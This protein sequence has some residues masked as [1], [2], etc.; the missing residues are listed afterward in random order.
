MNVVAIRGLL[1]SDPVVRQLTSGSV[2]ASLEVSTPI[3]GALASVPVAWFDPPEHLGLEMGTEVVV[4]GITRRRFF[5]S[6][7]VTQSR[8]EVVASEVVVATQKRKVRTV[9]ERAATALLDGVGSA[10]RSG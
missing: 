10:V 8:T 9:L 4:V 6:G 5:R 2:L 3:D 1:S 7:G